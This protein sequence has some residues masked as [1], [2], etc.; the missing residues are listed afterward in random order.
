MKDGAQVR[1]NTTDP[2]KRRNAA[3]RQAAPLRYVWYGTVVHYC[4]SPTPRR[5]G[6]A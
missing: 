2:S 3:M 6:V 1:R 5:N 4:A